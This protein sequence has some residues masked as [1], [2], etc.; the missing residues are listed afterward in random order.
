[1]T[2]SPISRRPGRR[3]EPGRRRGSSA[4]RRR[5]RAARA[6]PTVAAIAAWRGSRGAPGIGSARRLDDDR[7]AAAARGRA[8]RAARRR[9]GS[10]AR[11]GRRRRR[12]RSPRRGGGGG[13]STT[14][15]SRRVDDG[16]P[17]AGEE[18]DSGCARRGDGTAAD[19]MRSRVDSRRAE[20]ADRGG[21]RAR[22]RPARDAEL[23]LVDGNNLAYRAFFALPEELAT[24]DGFPTN[25]LLGFT[26]MLFKLLTDYRPKGVAVAWDTRPVHRRGARRRRT[27]R[28]AGRCRTCCASSSRTSARSSR[29]SA[30]GTSS[31]RAGRRTT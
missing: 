16:E 12:R 6:R 11:R 29:R 25:A 17:R 3:G 5:R 1:M 31:S 18:R 20:D 9:A 22:R 4:A 14:A 24:S 28:A 19:R 23:F 10:A 8:P 27:R 21:A 2:S 15:S 30:T 7:R 26:N 13:A